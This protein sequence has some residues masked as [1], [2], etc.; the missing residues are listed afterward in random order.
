MPNRKLLSIENPEYFDLL[1]QD[2]QLQFNQFRALIASDKFRYK[3]CNSG[4]TIELILSM[5]KIFCMKDEKTD[6]KRCLVCGVMFFEGK[7]ALNSKQLA[8]VLLKCRTTLN[9]VLLKAGYT[10]LPKNEKNYRQLEERIP[11]LQNHKTRRREWTIRKGVGIYSL[12]HNQQTS[13][14]QQVH[15]MVFNST[16]YSDAYNDFGNCFF[17]NDEN[18]NENEEN[19]ENLEDLYLAY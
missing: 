19:D 3:K 15:D 6:W 18:I 12:N 14:I 13:N 8:N 4:K 10:P 1:D 16:D 7:V 17:I 2:D 11:Y 5:I 9:S